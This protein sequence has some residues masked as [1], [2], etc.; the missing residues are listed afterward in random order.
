[1]NDKDALTLHRLASRLEAYEIDNGPMGS[2]RPFRDEA[3]RLRDIAD[4]NS[5]TPSSTGDFRDA[6]WPQR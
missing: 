3:K 6:D 5:N 2:Y 4:R 1:M